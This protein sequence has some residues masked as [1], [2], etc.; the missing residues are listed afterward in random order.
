MNPPAAGGGALSPRAAAGVALALLVGAVFWPVGGHQFVYDDFQYVVGNSQVQ[1]GFSFETLR[2]AFT[3]R[4]ASNWHPLT[5]LSHALD[6]Q[7][8]GLAP[9]GHHLVNVGLHALNAVLLFVVLA[10][11]TAAPWRSA[12]VAALFAVH[13]LHVES[14]AWISER[15][16]LLCTGLLLLALDAWRRYAARPS[17]ARYLAAASLFALALLAKP[18][19]VT[20]PLLLLL[21]DVWPLDRFSRGV[22]ALRLLLEKVPLLLLS[23]VSSALTVLAQQEGGSMRSVHQYTLAVRAGN[24][25][26]SAVAYLGKMLLPTGLSVFYPHP[27]PGLP[28]WQPVGAALLLAAITG[29]AV[30]SFRTRPWFGVGWLWYLVALVPV[31]GLVQVGDQGMA[32]RYTYL[33]LIGPFIVL[34]WGAGELVADRPRLRRAASAAAVALL[35]VLAATASRQVAWWKDGDTLFRRALAVTKN[36]WFAHMSLAGALGMQGD[37]AGAAAQYEEALK[38]RPHDPILLNNLGFILGRQ[39]RIEEAMANFREAS[40]L[41]P[42]YPE[43]LFN[44]GVLFLK[45]NQIDQARARCEALER[46]D[47]RWADQLREFIRYK[48]GLAPRPA[49]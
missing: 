6:V 39:G 10:R 29:L 7:L 8:F 28:P 4:F 9:R 1:Q 20:F 31:I 44:S 49:P 46:V 5:W 17:A 48:E 43:P 14:V 26:V 41:K 25:L 11:L 35:L 12:L 13:P 21:I 32:D 45:L 40:Q 47:R 33:P 24:A 42:D 2:W 16:E 38:I 36:N 23:A 34:V 30:R 37:L 27:G 15:K 18:M 19:A 22:P 3:S